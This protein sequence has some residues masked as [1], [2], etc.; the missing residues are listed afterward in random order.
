VGIPLALG[1]C[2][3]LALALYRRRRGHEAH[4]DEKDSSPNLVV[5][6]YQPILPG[7]HAQEA[8]GYPV[9]MSAEKGSRYSELYGSDVSHYS[10]ALSTGTNVTP[11][12]YS[13]RSAMSPGMTGGMA[14]I[15]EEPMELWGGDVPVRPSAVE[16]MNGFG[17]AR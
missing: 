5:A 13:P 10:P 14:S 1:G 12:Q 2:A 7:T 4:I 17:Q 11:P 15:T 3:I 9:A 8:G 16:E 6:N